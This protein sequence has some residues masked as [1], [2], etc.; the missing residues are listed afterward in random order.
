M[1]RRFRITANPYSRANLKRRTLARQRNR[2]RWSRHC[3][4]LRQRN[5]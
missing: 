1:M 3:A 4:R 5:V 2:L